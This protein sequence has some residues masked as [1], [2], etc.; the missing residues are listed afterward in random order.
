MA[1]HSL[2]FHTMSNNIIIVCTLEEAYNIVER[3]GHIFNVE[4]NEY[5]IC[6]YPENIMIA[7]IKHDEHLE[8][9][10]VFDMESFYRQ[11]RPPRVQKDGTKK[12]YN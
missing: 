8:F 1:N 3:E 4:L 9:L 10:H 6:N 2:S 7:L 5:E 12:C 11:P